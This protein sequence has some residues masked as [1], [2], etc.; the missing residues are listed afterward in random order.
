MRPRAAP[1]RELPLP[2][3]YRRNI[4]PLSPSRSRI[5]PCGWRTLDFVR[6][7]AGLPSVAT[8]EQQNAAGWGYVALSSKPDALPA[9]HAPPI[10][11]QRVRKGLGKN[12]TEHDGVSARGWCTS[13]RHCW[14]GWSIFSLCRSK[15]GETRAKPPIF[16]APAT[17]PEAPPGPSPLRGF[18][19]WPTLRPRHH[20]WPTIAPVSVGLLTLLR[21]TWPRRW[22]PPRLPPSR[23]APPWAGQPTAGIPPRS[24]AAIRRECASTFRFSPS[25]S[26]ISRHRPPP[27]PGGSTLG[28][29][30][31]HQALGCQ[32][33]HGGCTC[34]TRRTSRRTFQSGG[35]LY[36]PYPLDGTPPLL[37]KTISLIT[38][39]PR[40]SRDIPPP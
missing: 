23:P 3:Q 16:Q 37:E 24:P 17:A 14:R 32:A 15:F 26:R 6:G 1:R 21:P 40:D 39:V 18:R 29:G 35:I 4:A 28:P 30:P 38:A 13:V 9:R 36:P 19:R 33:R 12:A 5:F 31:P 20:R 2:I 7:E 25:L 10:S 27:P 22:V 34:L 11:Q 8:N